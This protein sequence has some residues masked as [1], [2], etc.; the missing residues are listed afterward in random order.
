M[1]VRLANK[2]DIETIMHIECASFAKDICESEETFLKRIDIAPSYFIV[3]EKDAKIVGY[4]CAEKW[5]TL[6]TGVT[7]FQ[8]NHDITKTHRPN[9]N[10]LYI[11][12][13][14]VLPCAR[15]HGNGKHFFESAL[16]FFL[17]NDKTISTFALIVNELW[18]NALSIY[19]S[20]GFIIKEIFPNFFLQNQNYSRALFMIS[21]KKTGLH[22]CG[23]RKAQ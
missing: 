14:A 12:S 13:F 23:T 16:N 9:G 11:S 22:A 17:E 18:Q 20:F 15:G 7:V 8:L 21:K 5:E 2:N 4:L 10:I 1:T 3:F 6:P 19:K